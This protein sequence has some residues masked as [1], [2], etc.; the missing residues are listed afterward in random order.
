M[1]AETADDPSLPAWA[2]DVEPTQIIGWYGLVENTSPANYSYY[3]DLIAQDSNTAFFPSGYT[4][5][6]SEETWDATIQTAKTTAAA[7][8]S[9]VPDILYIW[10]QYH[11]GSTPAALS[12]T[13][14]PAAQWSV[15]LAQ[16]AEA[17]FPA[18]VI[19]GG[20]STSGT[21]ATTCESGARSE[22][23][24]SV[25]QSFL[26]S[27]GDPQTDIAQG[28]VAS[29]SSTKVVGRGPDMAVDADPMTR[30]GSQY[31][32]PQWIELDL[33]SEQSI[34]G[35]RL[36]WETGYG[37]SYQIQ[38][39][40]NGTTWTSVYSTTAGT[41]CVENII[42]LSAS[43]RYIRFYGT[44]RG[45]CYGYSLWDFNVSGTA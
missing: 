25:T 19:W 40:N 16:I 17:G 3:Q 13:F 11:P 4:F 37:S 14:I 32:D 36:M 34:T 43:D 33:G 27:V 9:S 1:T 42:G 24:L 6:A 35:V 15:E 26:D 29:A 21:C 39:S 8:D 41:G 12:L 20:L 28:A 38:V 30:W 2:R 45:T 44:A 18:V 23:W 31:S 5:S 22:A 7:I 10:P